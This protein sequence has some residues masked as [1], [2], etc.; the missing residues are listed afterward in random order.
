[1]FCRSSVFAQVCP[2][3]VGY[4]RRQAFARLPLM[5]I[6]QL[7]ANSRLPALSGLSGHS[8]QNG[9][10]EKSHIKGMMSFWG[11]PTARGEKREGEPWCQGCLRTASSWV[12]LV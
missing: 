12:A 8:R 9:L 4:R 5:A 7:E 3:R 11:K 2:P 6:K 1:M 10:P